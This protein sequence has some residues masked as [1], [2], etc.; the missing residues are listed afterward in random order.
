MIRVLLLAGSAVLLAA[1]AGGQQT[2]PLLEGCDDL[3]VEVAPL[4]LDRLRVA[5]LQGRLEPAPVPVRRSG[6]RARRCRPRELSGVH[7]A[8]LPLGAAGEYR[9]AYPG[10]SLN[11]L[12]WGGRGA[13]LQARA[14]VEAAWGPVSAA[15]AP[16][17]AYQQNA[18]FVTL[19]VERPG[20]SRY[21]WYWAP[22]TIDWPQRFGGGSFGWSHPGE[23]YVRVDGF[24]VAAGASTESL[25]WG[26]A[27]LNP[28]LMSG[29]APG[30]PHVFLG[31]S[32]PVDVW[33]G[34]LAIEAVWGRLDESDY[35]DGDPENDHRLMAGVVAAIRPRGVNGLLLGFARAY[36]R[37]LPPGGMGLLDYLTEPYTDLWSN[38]A[39]GTFAGDNELFSL[40][41][42]WVFPGSEL[43]VYG[44]FARDD[45][46][47]GW[48]DLIQEPE[49][50]GGITAGLQKLVPVG[51][52]ASPRRLRVAAE[53][54]STNFSETQ[55]S[56]RPEVTFYTHS[57]VR[58][59]HTH[60]GQLLGAPVGPSSDAQ[61]F[62]LDYLAERWLAGF[63]FERVRYA[64][65]IYWRTFAR[66][67][68]YN[69][70]D[71]ELTGGARG[72]LLLPGGSIE[73]VGG[74]DW[75]G[76]YNRQ[77]IAL[78]AP[79]YN[80]GFEHNLSVR[81]GASWSPASGRSAPAGSPPSPPTRP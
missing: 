5:E 57:Q 74:L 3:G 69:G 2:L 72:A 21:A 27:R 7:L 24:G 58:Q 18:S 64:N 65:D 81:L 33:I 55:R 32:R 20:S 11:G 19:P 76:R 66:S 8:L 4:H 63:R 17:F 45:Q 30:F 34:D 23:S 39:G 36:H 70:H 51:R 68:T 80:T 77:F 46:W 61:T 75:S 67:Y 40:F 12:R 13:S 42:R 31:T 53:I 10:E 62:E 26:P 6:D 60:V 47:A 14:G 22:T 1:D 59:G 37:T 9:S 52:G 48:D 54:T 56:G 29:A 71:V 16:A 38:P 28:L 25:R 41:A 78:T 15:F 50:S 79:G 35:F 43:E 49:H 44:E 73:L